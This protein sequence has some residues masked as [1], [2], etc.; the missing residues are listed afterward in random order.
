[1]KLRSNKYIRIATFLIAVIMCIL[2]IPANALDSV[3][4]EKQYYAD[5]AYGK[6]FIDGVNQPIRTSSQLDTQIE[7]VGISDHFNN[8]WKVDDS[9]DNNP[10]I[11]AKGFDEY[12]RDRVAHQ[13]FTTGQLLADD[14]PEGLYNFELHRIKASDQRGSSCR[15][16]YHRGQRISVSPRGL[17]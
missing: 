16:C 10:W 6:I 14:K 2:T 7:N 12:W 1:M 8:S 9:D 3:R 17:A 15:I 11:S 5:I 4:M 13:D